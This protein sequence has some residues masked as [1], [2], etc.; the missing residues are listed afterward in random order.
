MYGGHRAVVGDGGSTP[1]AGVVT[2]TQLVV[3]ILR[4]WR[5]D[6]LTDSVSPDDRSSY[7]ARI[8][9]RKGNP[10]AVV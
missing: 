4:V 9:A 1:E 5:G 6:R 2:V 10:R 3:G 7:A 8:D